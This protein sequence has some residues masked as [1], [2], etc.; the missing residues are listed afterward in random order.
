M[1]AAAVTE[2]KK[3]KRAAA[4]AAAVDAAAERQNEITGGTDFDL[5]FDLPRFLLQKCER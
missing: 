1:A 3:V 5:R 4:V 2:E